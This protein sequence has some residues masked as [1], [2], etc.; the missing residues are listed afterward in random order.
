M[1]KSQRQN[2]FLAWLDVLA[3]ASWGILMLRYWVTGKLNLLIHPNF[4]GL[5]VVCGVAL[6]VI[7]F[8]KAKELWQRRRREVTPNVQHV[9]FFAPGW[10]SSLLLISAIVGIIITPQV[11]AS[12]K[13]LQRGVTELTN[14]RV[15]PQAFRAST[16][17]EERSLV[18]W[19][20]TLSVYPEPDGYTGQKVKVQGFVIHPPDMGKEYIFLA[21]F[22]L[23][24][25][26]A[27][28]YPVGLPVKLS[29]G[30]ERYTPDT[31]LEIEGKMVTE[32]ISGKRQL[33]IAA[34]SLKKIPQPPNPYSY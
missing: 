22:V 29:E 4:F 34:S 23:T 28:A 8:L 14:S 17:P 18:D 19:V 15:Q 7:A 24:C 5:V 10:G 3:I 21:R 31:W 30:Q 33:T 1:T 26:A 20:R 11:F 32:T 12:D 27:D 16:R 25:C 6:I 13:A 2:K 9:N